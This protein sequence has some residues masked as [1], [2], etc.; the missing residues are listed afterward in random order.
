MFLF[1]YCLYLH[2][3]KCKEIKKKKYKKGINN[4]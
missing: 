3:M 4:R 2:G 1:L